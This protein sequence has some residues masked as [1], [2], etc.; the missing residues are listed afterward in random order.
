MSD[1]VLEVKNLNIQYEMDFYR[2]E[3]LRDLFVGMVNGPLQTLFGQRDMYHIIRDL[4]LILHRGDRLGIIGI[5]GSGKTTLCRAIAGMLTP[6]SGEVI[7]NGEIRPIFD[8]NVGVQWEL[9]GRENAMLLSLFLYPNVDR[10]QLCEIVNESLEFSELGEFVDIPFK[11]Y[12]KGMQARLCLSLVTARPTDILILDEVF[13]GADYFFQQK[14][15]TRTLKIIKE[16]GS[17]IL[18][19]HNSEQF[20]LACNRMIV[21]GD[22]QILFDGGVEEALA[23]YHSYGQVDNETRCKEV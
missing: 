5:N 14:I 21:L 7:V 6:D 22:H 11:K 20:K 1:I 9:T 23:Y 2:S 16:S 4:N 10:K 18:I 13:D 8:T 15:S 17:V 3:S 19:S 12:S